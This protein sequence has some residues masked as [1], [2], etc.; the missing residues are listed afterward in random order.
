MAKL[1]YSK[2]A[3]EDIE[4]LVDFL[5]DLDLLSALSTFDIVDDGVQ[6]LKRHPEIGCLVGAG[7][8][9]LVI[10]RGNTGYIAIYEFD[11]LV[12]TIVVLAVKH[13]REDQFN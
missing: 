5:M 9:E 13:Q 4:R 8:R 2:D 1:E 3:L 10:S 11:K 6:L 12:N 7:K